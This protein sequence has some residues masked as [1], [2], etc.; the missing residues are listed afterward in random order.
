MYDSGTSTY[1]WALDKSMENFVIE[2]YKSMRNLN[3]LPSIL[4]Q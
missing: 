4:L 2:K 1:I 3:A